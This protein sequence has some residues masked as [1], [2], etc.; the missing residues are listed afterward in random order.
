MI[1]VDSNVIAYCWLR[2]ERTELAQRVRV[3]DSAWHVP[4]LWRSE[5]RSALV[6]Y[7]R[8]GSLATDHA[9]AV[10]EAAEAALEG[11]EH[12]V[13]SSTVLEIA[14]RMRLSAYD[15]EFVALAQALAVPLVTEDAAILKAF[16]ELALDMEG[17]LAAYP[18]LPPELHQRPASYRV[19]RQR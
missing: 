18:A 19:A 3:R 8:Q 4:I 10:M 11:C 2:S 12:V 9:L 6:G 1:V 13:S 17:Y 7:V 14:G 15:C 5:V 16:P